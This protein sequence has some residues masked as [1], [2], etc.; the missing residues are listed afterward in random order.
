MSDSKQEYWERMFGGVNGIGNDA[1]ECKNKSSYDCKKAKAA[2]ERAHDIRKFEIELLWK[3]AAYA[4]TFQTLLF[5]AFGVTFASDA[6]LDNGLV[7]FFRFIITITGIFSS[8]LGILINKG[9]KFWQENCETHIDLL[10]DEFEG[11]LQKTVLHEPNQ[12]TFSVSRTNIAISQLFF[13]V[14]CVLSIVFCYL[15]AG[16]TMDL[17][18]DCLKLKAMLIDVIA[19]AL[20]V[21]MLFWLRCYLKSDFDDENNKKVHE[22]VERHVQIKSGNRH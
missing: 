19:I 16:G 1:T 8:F 17:I 18:V 14:W 12:S 6:N 13:W 3:R 7:N 21:P 10:E 4:A 2:L 5:T 11:K 15:F 22:V 9:S 20:V